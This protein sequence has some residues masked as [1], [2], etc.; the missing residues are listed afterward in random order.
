MDSCRQDVWFIHVGILVWFSLGNFAS[1]L[2]TMLRSNTRTK[3]L[4]T[5]AYRNFCNVRRGTTSKNDLLDVTL[6][7]L[8]LDTAQPHS[9]SGYIAA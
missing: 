3:V 4:A 9:A 5:V 6:S 2:E 8:P 7:K 1:A